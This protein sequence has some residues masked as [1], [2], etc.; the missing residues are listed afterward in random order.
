MNG[1]A[2]LVTQVDDRS[3]DAGYFRMEMHPGSGGFPI[4]QG[5]VQTI[6]EKHGGVA[7]GG[8]IQGLVPALVTEKDSV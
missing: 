3:E 7:A 2:E 4:V 5:T 6:D 1:G 8:Y